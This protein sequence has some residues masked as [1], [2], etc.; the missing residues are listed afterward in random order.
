MALFYIFGNI[1]CL[2]VKKTARSS[3]LLLHQ[4]AGIAHYSASGELYTDERM[5]VK[6]KR[7]LSIITNIVLDLWT[8]GKDPGNPQGFSNLTLRTS[9][10]AEQFLQ[11]CLKIVFWELSEETQHTPNSRLSISKVTHLQKKVRVSLTLTAFPVK[12]EPVALL[13]KALV[14]FSSRSPLWYCKAIRA[15]T[16]EPVGLRSTCFRTNKDKKVHSSTSTSHDFCA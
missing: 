8:H 16:P 3:Y 15:V 14:W 1:Q 5:K 11:V 9:I 10:L 6:S 12:T 7:C 2:A 4:S 13:L